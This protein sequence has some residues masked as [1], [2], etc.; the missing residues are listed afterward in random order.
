[1]K[2]DDLRTILREQK[3]AVTVI[4]PERTALRAAADDNLEMVT[5]Y[6]LDGDSFQIGRAHV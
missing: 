5:A 3:D 6:L 2:I 4:P 1:M